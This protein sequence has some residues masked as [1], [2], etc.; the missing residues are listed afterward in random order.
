MSL[1]DVGSAIVEKFVERI[2]AEV[3]VNEGFSAN[4]QLAFET[5]LAEVIYLGVARKDVKNHHINIIA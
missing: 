1:I 2:S 5:G 3:A 4:E